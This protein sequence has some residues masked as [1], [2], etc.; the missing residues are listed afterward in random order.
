MHAQQA[1]HAPQPPSMQQSA[2]AAAAQLFGGAS[3]A[4]GESISKALVTICNH[5]GQQRMAPSAPLLIAADTAGH[6]HP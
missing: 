1:E 2:Q 4:A 3:A 5:M 6:H